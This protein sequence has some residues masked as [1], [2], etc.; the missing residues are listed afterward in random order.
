MEPSLRILFLS[1]YFPPEMGA[2]S[3]RTYE[4]CR[5]WVNQNQRVTV[6]T[7]FPNHPTGVIP[8][9]YK[10]HLFKIEQTDGIRVIRTYVY[11]APN[12]GF[13]KRIISYI[14]FMFSSVL[15][16]PWR[17]CKV[18]LVI[19]TSPQFLVAIAGY[20]ISLIKRA[21]FIF[22]VRDLWPE[23]IVQLGQIRNRMIIKMLEFLEIFLYKKA[24]MIVVVAESSIPILKSKGIPARKIKVVKNG[25]DLTLFHP[26][27]ADRQLRERLGFTNKFIVSYIGTLGLSHALDKVLE[28]A[29]SLREQDHIQ[30]LLIGEGAEKERLLGMK[31][32]LNLNNVTFLNQVEKQLLPYYY[33]LSDVVLVTLRKLPLF[34]CVIPSKIFEIMAM[35][36]PIIIGVDGEARQLVVDEAGAGI[37]VEPENIQQLGETILKLYKDPILRKTL[38]DNGRCFV[39]KHYDREKLARA[40]LEALEGLIT[41]RRSTN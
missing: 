27:K 26:Q 33:N 18:D 38:G 35:A 17:A 13:L 36:K 5:S 6:I 3:A 9:E 1:Q 37:F 31:D 41:N 29:Q 39:Q 30:F 34:Q 4:L 23:S 20:I 16:G 40:Y 25:V 28:T 19:A 7:G 10:Q 12:E 21:P 8:K 15:I 2:P 11:P 32:E 24:A 22:E 14:S